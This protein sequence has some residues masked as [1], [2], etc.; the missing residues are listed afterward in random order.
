MRYTM[1]LRRLEMLSRVQ[2]PLSSIQ[3]PFQQR[4]CFIKCEGQRTHFGSVFS[5]VTNLLVNKEMFHQ[6]SFCLLRILSTL[7]L[8]FKQRSFHQSQGTCPRLLGYTHRLL[9]ENSLNVS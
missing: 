5:N 1:G 7:Q 6:S 9:S 3:L 2:L 4:M 8:L